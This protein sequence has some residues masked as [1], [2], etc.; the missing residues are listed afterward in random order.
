MYSAA[1]RFDRYENKTL[2][3]VEQD[4][5]AE[6]QKT[7]SKARRSEAEYQTDANASETFTDFLDGLTLGP[8][9]GPLFQKKQL[10]P[11]SLVF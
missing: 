8:V 9:E 1:F 4:V 3:W 5:M 7:T 2:Y 11:M 10:L 6:Y